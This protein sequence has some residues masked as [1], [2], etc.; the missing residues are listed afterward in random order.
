MLVD[1]ATAVNVAVETDVFVCVAVY[2]WVKVFTGVFVLTT[3]AVPKVDVAVIEPVGATTAVK[4]KTA[5]DTGVFK[6]AEI[7]GSVIAAGETC[8]EQAEIN[9]INKKTQIAASIFFIIPSASK[10]Q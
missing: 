1:V 5:V 10:L 7:S 3:V 6:S 2:V 9:A 8:L 4:F